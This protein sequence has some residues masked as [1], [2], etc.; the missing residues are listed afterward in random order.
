FIPSIIQ[1]IILGERE[2]TEL[3]NQTVITLGIIPQTPALLEKAS[4]A[5]VLKETRK[6]SMEE[7]NKLP[8]VTEEEK[9]DV[10]EVVVTEELLSQSP[11]KSDLELGKVLLEGKLA[12]F[13]FE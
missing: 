9:Q 7:M 12:E 13:L 4:G 10:V 2:E 6:S 5:S 1:R 3:L 8:V 11:V